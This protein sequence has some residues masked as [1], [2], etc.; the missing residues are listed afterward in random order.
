MILKKET[1]DG[2]FT[3]ERTL[4]GVI[5]SITNALGHRIKINEEITSNGRFFPKG[6]K[7]RVIQINEPYQSGHSTDVITCLF[8]AKE[9]GSG[10]DGRLV[11]L[12]FADLDL[13]Q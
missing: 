13:S 10:I 7:G 9:S 11:D 5:L 12:K 2:G 3:I 1:I 6:A 8:D 4:A